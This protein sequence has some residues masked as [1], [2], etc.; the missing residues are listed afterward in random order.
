MVSALLVLKLSKWIL[1]AKGPKAVSKSVVSGQ[2][3][4]PISLHVSISL[5]GPCVLSVI[6][7]SL[8]DHQATLGQVG[9]ELRSDIGHVLVSIL[10]SPKVVKAKLAVEGN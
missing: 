10:G 6:Q 2:T 7:I 3:T 1:P 8:E 5:P 9:H 4:S